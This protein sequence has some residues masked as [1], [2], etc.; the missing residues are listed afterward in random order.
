MPLDLSH[1]ALVAVPLL[2]DG[3]Q[4]DIHVLAPGGTSIFSADDTVAQPSYVVFNGINH[5]T[6][7]PEVFNVLYTSY[8]TSIAKRSLKFFTVP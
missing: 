3:N 4:R 8:V 5:S 6:L 7:E 2:G 1:L